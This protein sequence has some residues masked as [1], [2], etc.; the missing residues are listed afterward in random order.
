[1]QILVG[2]T[3]DVGPFFPLPL[4]LDGAEFLIYHFVFNMLPG[5]SLSSR[6][7]RLAGKLEGKCPQLG[8]GLFCMSL[9]VCAWYVL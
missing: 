4:F 6:K 5:L 7:G 9:R 3:T 8:N 2:R 1:M